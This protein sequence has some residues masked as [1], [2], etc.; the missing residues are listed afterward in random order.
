MDAAC[1]HSLSQNKDKRETSS[2]CGRCCPERRDPPRRPPH[3]GPGGG[4]AHLDTRCTGIPTAPNRRRRSCGRLGGG[5]RVQKKKKQKMGETFFFPWQKLTQKNV[6]GASA[7]LC[8]CRGHPGNCE[9][10]TGKYIFHDARRSP[11]R[12]SCT[13]GCQGNRRHK[14]NRRL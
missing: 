9:S 6:N 7:Y 3:T 14:T 10:G 5:Q 11:A 12:S 4:G 13:W 2:Y 1:G 8:T